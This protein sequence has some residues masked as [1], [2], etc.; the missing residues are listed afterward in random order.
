MKIGKEEFTIIPLLR[1][2]KAAHL[3]IQSGLVSAPADVTDLNF[4]E[5]FERVERP[6]FSSDILSLDLMDILIECVQHKSVKP[7]LLLSF[8][9][10]SF[11]TE[12]VEKAIAANIPIYIIKAKPL[13]ESEET[14]FRKLLAEGV[15]I[16][17]VFT[18][19]KE[20]NL[21]AFLMSVPEYLRR[22]VMICYLP[23]VTD[24]D[25]LL[26]PL[27]VS[28]RLD[29][30]KDFLALYGINIF[31]LANDELRNSLLKRSFYLSPG[32]EEYRKIFK[33]NFR[34]NFLFYIFSV[35]SF[36]RF[37]VGFGDSLKN[38]ANFSRQLLHPREKLNELRISIYNIIKYRLAHG[39]QNF[40]I[41][42]Y[43]RVYPLKGF[44]KQMG[45]FL[46]WK[47]RRTTQASLVLVNIAGIKLYWKAKS[48]FL[49]SKVAIH[50][51]KA[52]Y[53]TLH[54]SWVMRP[55][56]KAYWF[57]EYQYLTRVLRKKKDEH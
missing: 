14:K 54:Q 42:A 27:E 36:Y 30:N 29:K 5:T 16:R 3:L 51:L 49:N 1:E 52:G 21:Y 18:E 15:Q 26:S 13:L 56:L 10:L 6:I 35:D 7:S 9:D 41:K 4:I 24:W 43:W 20:N 25:V 50:T 53:W 40:F 55:F 2:S 22:Y 39:V 34:N 37:L 57:F 11:F 48:L 45:I 12:S 23:K 17:L 31:V 32:K 38:I 47:L 46:Y 44:A 8:Y 33:E 28:E 19:T